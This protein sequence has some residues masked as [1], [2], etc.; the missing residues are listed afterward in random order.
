M[1]QLYYRL[2]VFF[3]L[4]KLGQRKNGKIFV[5]MTKTKRKGDMVST[6][7]YIQFKTIKYV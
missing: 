4:Y 2:M 3:G 5:K 7:D 1:K 6:D